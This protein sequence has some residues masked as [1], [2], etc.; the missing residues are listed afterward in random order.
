MNKWQLNTGSGV[1]IYLQLKQQIIQ[2]IL[3]GDWP[4]GH[5]LPTVRQ[6]AVDVR[7]NVNTV[8]R[9]YAEVEREG[10]ITTQQGRGTFV[11]SPFSEEH[12]PESRAQVTQKFVELVIQMALAQG[13]SVQEL[14][15]GLQSAARS[16]RD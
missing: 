15:E 9:V 1:P 14:V 11:S 6:L 7:I 13:I 4:P 16:T 5:Q 3:L 8:S 2:K 10:L 12:S